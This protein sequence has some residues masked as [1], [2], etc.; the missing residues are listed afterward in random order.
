[1]W[2]AAHRPLRRYTLS[3]VLVLC[4]TVLAAQAYD[5]AVGLRVG[6]SGGLSAAQRLG[7]HAS[8]EGYLAAGL[9]DSGIT[10]TLLWRRHLPL[11]TKRINLFVGAGAHKGWNY[12]EEGKGDA[13][14]KRGNPLGLDGQVGAEFAFGRTNVAF[15]YNVQLNFSG[16]LSPIRPPGAAL[17]VRYV[18]NKRNPQ[19][20]IKRPWETDDEAKARWKAKDKRRKQRAREKKARRKAKAKAKRKGEWP[21]LWERLGLK[22]SPKPRSARE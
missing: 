1:M 15:D 19:L 9:F 8:A 6:R 5:T 7:K 10:A 14:D 2:K 21:S 18:L 13:D 3:L 22:D 20:H 17:T 16:S 12:V 4:A 11:V